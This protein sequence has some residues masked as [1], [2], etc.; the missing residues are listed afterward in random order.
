MNGELPLPWKYLIATWLPNDPSKGFYYSYLY[1]LLSMHMNVYVREGFRGNGKRFV[2]G[3]WN[4]KSLTDSWLIILT[5]SSD[6]NKMRGLRSFQAICWIKPGR[7][8]G[9]SLK[10]TFLETINFNSLS[11]NPQMKIVW[12]E[13]VILVPILFDFHWILNILFYIY[14]CDEL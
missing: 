14:H 11:K 3:M 7:I 4:W 10:S 6:L 9:L 12:V 8:Q 2:N 13:N 1:A 5:R